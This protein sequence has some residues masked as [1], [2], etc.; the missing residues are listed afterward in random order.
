MYSHI[1]KI[2]LRAFNWQFATKTSKLTLLKTL[3][4]GVGGSN[5]TLYP[6]ANRLGQYGTGDIRDDD[7]DDDDVGTADVTG[8]EWNFAY[9][10]PSDCLKFQRI[11]SG[12]RV[13]VRETK[14][15]FKRGVILYKPDSD[16]DGKNTEVIFYG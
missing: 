2:V 10:Y 7:D 8:P 1:L 11:L 14:V 13:D 3:G 9:V 6:T 16:T 15:S 4:G 5:Q 12:F